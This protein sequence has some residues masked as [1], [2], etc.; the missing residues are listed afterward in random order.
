MI[1]LPEHECAFCS[2]SQGLP[3]DY[4]L[5]TNVVGTLMRIEQVEVCT[6]CYHG[7]AASGWLAGQDSPPADPRDMAIFANLLLAEIRKLAR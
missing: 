1:E 2:W 4:H 6:F 5:A 7:L 3:E